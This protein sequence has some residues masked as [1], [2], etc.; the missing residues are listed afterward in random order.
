[1][2]FLSGQGH[3]PP[4]Q[5]VWCAYS[6]ICHLPHMLTYTAQRTH[7]EKEYLHCEHTIIFINKPAVGISQRRTCFPTN[8][9]PQLHTELCLVCEQGPGPPMF[10]P[11]SLILPRLCEVDMI[12]CVLW[13]KKLRSKSL[14]WVH[15][16]FP[17]SNRAL[18]TSSVIPEEDT[19]MEKL[20]VYAGLGGMR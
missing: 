17:W 8:A 4:L 7:V 18:L 5:L 2:S 12:T 16:M 15:L 20:S 3:H 6:H 9:G 13:M 11:S 10:L 14:E 1:M 19:R